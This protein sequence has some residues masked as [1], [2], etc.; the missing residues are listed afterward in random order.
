M[1]VGTSYVMKIPSGTIVVVNINP[2][3]FS[4]RDIYR[5]VIRNTFFLEHELAVFASPT[6]AVKVL[7]SSSN[8]TIDV[9]PF[10]GGLGILRSPT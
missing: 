1:R 6:P 9:L 4:V 8:F 5:L 10:V 7:W 2:A 3:A